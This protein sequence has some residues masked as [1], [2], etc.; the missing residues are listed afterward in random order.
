MKVREIMT[1]GAITV[2]PD[3]SI[4]DA[5]SQMLKH[6]VS[7]LPVVS[8]AEHLVGIVTEG[9]LMRCAET[10]SGRDRPGWLIFLYGSGEGAENEA[11]V[12]ARKVE[13][14]MTR[15]VVSVTPGTPVEEAVDLFDGLG[16]KRLPVL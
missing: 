6:R 10:G 11:R 16:L 1:L 9:D 3:A 4:A 2:S 7:G 12:H 5:A 13:D 8:F 15:E 14:A